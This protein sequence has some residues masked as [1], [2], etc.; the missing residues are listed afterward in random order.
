[1]KVY[2]R[3]IA[4]LLSAAMIAVS[5]S[6]KTLTLHAWDGDLH[7]N[8]MKQVLLLGTN[9]DYEYPADI[10]KKTKAEIIIQDLN[11]ASYLAIDLTGRGNDSTK[12]SDAS[13]FIV[14]KKK[15]WRF[16]NPKTVDDIAIPSG[17]GTGGNGEH[18]KYT[19]LGWNHNYDDDNFPGW[20]N[21]QWI[22]RRSI[23][24]NTVNKDL[25]FGIL[26]NKL[27][28]D[29]DPQCVAFS[30][31]LYYI[32]VL[33]DDISDFQ[34][35]SYS[36]Y[37][38]PEDTIWFAGRKGFTENSKD[39]A[40]EL[41]EIMPIL[42]PDHTKDSAA[43]DCYKDLER[44]LKTIDEEANTIIDSGDYTTSAGYEELK[45]LAEKEMREALT[46]NIPTLLRNENFFAKY[47]YDD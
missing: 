30:E 43:N 26:S 11:D 31:L 1:M 33:G 12:A 25:D 42:F 45:K 41:L 7:N 47:F 34:K 38:L 44:R 35:N 15:C 28:L 32:H 4:V 40:D 9:N 3:F 21:D 5:I 39:I 13:K 17:V 24:L 22:Q 19:H 6:C 2:H 46:D 23:L 14:L 27:W 16:S 18:D 37:R 36:D 29:Y 20:S 10:E 8:F